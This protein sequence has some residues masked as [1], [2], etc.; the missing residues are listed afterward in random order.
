MVGTAGSKRKVL[1]RYR[2]MYTNS[3]RWVWRR[4]G[5]AASHA[6]S[7][8]E[9]HILMPIT[10]RSACIRVICTHLRFNSFFATNR[11]KRPDG[12][13]AWATRQVSSL[14]GIEDVLEVDLCGHMIRHTQLRARA[15]RRNRSSLKR[16]C[17]SRPSQ[18]V[19]MHLRHHGAIDSENHAKI[20]DVGY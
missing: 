7:Q 6:G 5:S 20:S 13:A 16:A 4:R 11:S 14:V 18:D 10:G 12:V 19:T 9:P 2:Q 8:C 3:R 1:R 17:R 15:R